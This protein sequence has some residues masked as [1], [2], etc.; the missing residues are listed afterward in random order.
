MRTLDQSRINGKRY[1]T[2]E[3]SVHK[4]LFKSIVFIIKLFSFVKTVQLRKKR[5]GQ[6][7]DPYLNT[8]FPKAFS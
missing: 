7:S 8:T 2:H 3:E 6:G 5:N 1:A 4:V